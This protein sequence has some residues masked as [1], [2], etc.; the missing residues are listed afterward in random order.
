MKKK[1]LSDVDLDKREYMGGL[2]MYIAALCLLG[3]GECPETHP[4]SKKRTK[5]QPRKS[6]KVQPHAAR[7]SILNKHKK[8]TNDKW[9]MTN[10]QK[11]T[12]C[13]DRGQKSQSLVTKYNPMLPKT[14]QKLLL[15]KN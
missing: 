1:R 10:A 8:L 3:I 9:H 11:P 5:V 4:V 15:M 12:Q 14:N 6:H 7:F 2:C 13:P